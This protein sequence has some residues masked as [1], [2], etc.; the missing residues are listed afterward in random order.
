MFVE[1]VRSGLLWAP[2]ANRKVNVRPVPTWLGADTTAGI[3]LLDA[4]VVE[5][6]ASGIV[7]VPL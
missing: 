3:E 7:S 1:V 5:V 4:P 6:H 2:G